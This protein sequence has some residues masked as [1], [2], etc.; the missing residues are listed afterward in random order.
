MRR[1]PSPLARGV[2]PVLLRA[3]PGS[4]ACFRW[5]SS[6]SPARAFT[7]SWQSLAA[8]VNHAQVRE[9]RPRPHGCGPRGFHSVVSLGCRE[10]LWAAGAPR[11]LSR[12]LR[13]GDRLTGTWPGAGRHGQ[14]SEQCWFPRSRW[15]GLLAGRARSVLRLVPLAAG[16]GAR[17]APWRACCLLPW[18]PKLHS[19]QVAAASNKDEDHGEGGGKT[20]FPD[21]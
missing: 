13:E 1:F 8:A 20:A 10:R 3:Q 16:W 5:V 17:A 21:L 14:T 11:L 12:V 4:G 19:Y 9:A 7:T 6:A 2:R 18:Q 15:P